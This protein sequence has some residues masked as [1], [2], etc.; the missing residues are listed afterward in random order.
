MS[1]TILA[2]PEA[3]LAR[4]VGQCWGCLV[5]IMITS[6]INTTTM[7]WFPVFFVLMV[8]GDRDTD[9]FSRMAGI[10]VNVA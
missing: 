7:W 1:G 6:I 4:G 9:C 2:Q 3:C 8:G 10:H 5:A